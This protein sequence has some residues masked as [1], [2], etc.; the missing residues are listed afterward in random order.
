[1]IKVPFVLRHCWSTANQ[2]FY[3]YTAGLN[4]KLHENVM[5]R[6]EYRY[7]WATNEVNPFI[8][9]NMNASSFGMDMVLTY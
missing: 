2:E 5:L 3:E 1:M 7:Q 9:G 6:P 4:I 8:G